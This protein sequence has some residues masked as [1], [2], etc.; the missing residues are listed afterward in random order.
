MNYKVSS[1]IAAILAAQAAYPAETTD[2]AAS[3][4]AS[5]QIE[6]I[7]VTATRRS[8]SLQDVPIAVSAITGESLEKLHVQTFDDYVKFLP[9]VSAGSTGPGASNIYMRGLSATGTG[10]GNQVGGG[11]GGFPNVAVYIDDQSA[12][13]PGRNLDVYAADLERIEIL[14]GPQGTLFGAGAQAGAV[15]YITNKPNPNKVD[16][17]FSA[18]YSATA[19][20]DPNGDVQGF[21][22]LPVLDGKAAVRLVV[23]TDSRGGYIRNVP[24]TFSRKPT[25]LGIAAQNF[26]SAGDPGGLLGFG[27]PSKLYFVSRFNGQVPGQS[28]CKAANGANCTNV[29]RYTGP[30]VFGDP[31]KTVFGDAASVNTVDNSKV[32]NPHYNPV[33]YRGARLSGVYRFND[34]WDL[35]VQYSNQ[36]MKADGVFGY[37]KSLGDLAVNEFNQ[38][39]NSDKFSDYALTLNGKIGALK[40]VYTGGYLSRSVDQITDYTH[41]ARGNY[42]TY[43]NCDGPNV[44]GPPA[45]YTGNP[46][47]RRAKDICFS[48]SQTWHD[49]QKNTHQNH[50]IRLSTPDDWRIRGIVGG[51]YEDFKIED[52]ANF[53]Y[54]SPD[55]GFHGQSPDPKTTIFDPSVRPEGTGFFNDITRGYKQKAGFGE[56]AFDVVPK[57]L[58]LSAGVRFYNM[59]TYEKGSDFS[60]YGNRYVP[61]GGP[62]YYPKKRNLDA[63]NLQETFTGHSDKVTLSWKPTDDALLYATYSTGFRPGGFNRGTISTRVALNVPLAYDSDHLTNKE[64]GWKTSWWGRRIVFNGAVYQEDW[65]DIQYTVFNPNVSNLTFSLNGPTYRVRGTEEDVTVRLTDKLTLQASASWNSSELIRD[66]N[67]SFGGVPGSIGTAGPGST[68]ANSPPFQGS[69]R[70]R[71]DFQ[72]NDY[73]AYWQVAAKHSAHTYS[74]IT[75]PANSCVSTDPDYTNCLIVSAF[76]R[77]NNDAYTIVD[78]SAGVQK[79]PWTVSFVVNNVTDKRADLTNYSNQFVLLTTTNVPRTIGIRLNYKMAGEGR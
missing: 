46:A 21:L 65:K 4:A 11:V 51:F 15:R 5:G 6:E 12:Q 37:D 20:G 30:F 1:A 59:D 19:H 66:V 69:L 8:E 26:I 60:S 7:T 74:S 28:A 67:V 61:R 63:Q 13:L 24:G 62:A 2:Q 79:G 36:A 16:A 10:V 14:E 9:N 45:Y 53:V 32:V 49:I 52:S 77:W 43:Y 56:I 75:A 38:S 78:A 35:L 58:T 39:T 57:K 48:P 68:L 41:Y 71:Y 34:D 25:D 22:N 44:Y 31:T 29:N 72:Y 76:Q 18:G 50:E 23:Y 70:A 54:A 64:I 3:A 47:T 73:N 40:A 42:S 17:G 27:G 55:A 33:T